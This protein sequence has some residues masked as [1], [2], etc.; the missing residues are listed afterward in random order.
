[1]LHHKEAGGILFYTK[2]KAKQRKTT[3]KKKKQKTEVKLWAAN[4]IRFP[5][6]I[7][8]DHAGLQACSPYRLRHLHDH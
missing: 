4:F 7:R 2:K 1:M 5:M 6:L 3:E 8:S